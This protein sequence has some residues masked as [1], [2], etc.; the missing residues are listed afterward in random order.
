MCF[1]LNVFY[2]L[3]QEEPVLPP[4]EKAPFITFVLG[5]FWILV[6]NM[7]EPMSWNL[8]RFLFE[9]PVKKS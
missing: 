1:V 4:K 6:L 3:S 9:F 8:S 2:Y 7:L 5:Q